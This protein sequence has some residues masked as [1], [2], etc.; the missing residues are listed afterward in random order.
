V[1]GRLINNKRGVYMPEIP[2]F[3][4]D[5][6]IIEKKVV[7]AIA[8]KDILTLKELKMRLPYYQL[9]YGQRRKLAKRIIEA[10]ADHT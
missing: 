1:N 6:I 3:P 8:T 5:D 10:L 9:P 7:R 4:K 2:S